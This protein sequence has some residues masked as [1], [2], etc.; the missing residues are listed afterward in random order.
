MGSKLNYFSLSTVAAAIFIIG[1]VAVAAKTTQLRDGTTEDTSTII[2]KGDN[3]ALLVIDVQECFMDITGTGDPGSLAVSNTS[4]IIPIINKIRKEAGCVFDMVVRSQ[5]LHPDH[6]ISFASTFGLEPFAHLTKKGGLPLT[7][8]SADS[9]L[10]EDSAC[11]PTYYVNRDL[12]DCEIQLC[13]SPETTLDDAMM[14]VI[15]STACD[16]CRESPGECFETTQAM[17][18]DHCL[19]SGDSGFPVDLYTKPTD[20]VV[21]KGGN[22]HVDSYSA[23]MD[24][25]KKLKT[26]LDDTLM[27]LSVGTIYMVGIATDYCVYF[28]ALDALSLGY[29]VYIVTD[30]M[31]GISESGVAAALADMEEKGATLITSDEM[32]SKGCPRTSPSIVV[33]SSNKYYYYY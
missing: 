4:A 16:Q 13:P 15:N 17:W 2:A 25:T 12:V 10:T 20:V 1:N 22:V 14:S 6:H 3:T 18:T 26:S 30:A 19:R 7:C 28:S 21:E 9:G 8:H 29:E 27:D 32:F 24:N 11:C 33:S 23:F 31:R 5:D